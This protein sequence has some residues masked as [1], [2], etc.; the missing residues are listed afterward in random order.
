MY[1]PS[2]IIERW[3]KRVAACFLVISGM[4]FTVL[5]WPSSASVP[6]ALSSGKCT[7]TILI[8]VTLLFMDKIFYLEP[9]LYVICFKQGIN[10]RKTNNISCCFDKKVILTSPPSPPPPPCSL[11]NRRNFLRDSGEQR[12]KR[13]EGEASVKRDLNCMWEEDC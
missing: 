1:I 7:C 11:Q 12:R 4:I 5:F 8:H 6:R 2:F 9:W 10:V 13:G 3:V